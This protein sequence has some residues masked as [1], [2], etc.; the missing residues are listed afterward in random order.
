MWKLNQKLKPVFWEKMPA[1]SFF[2]F[3]LAVFFLFSSIGFVIDILNLGEV[4]VQKLVRN[5]LY[6]GLVA[7]GFAYSF[8]KNIKMLPV[9]LIFQFGFFFLPWDT[10]LPND[11]TI[12]QATQLYIDG[13]GIL[14]SIV[15]SY[16]LFV[17]FISSQGIKQVRLRAEMDIAGEMHDVLVPPINFRN[18]NLC[19]Y[20]KSLPALEVGGDLIDLYEKDGSLTCYIADVS[21]HGISAGLFN[22]YV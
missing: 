3:V 18:E 7:T 11:F 15:I 9:T 17:I 16:T 2:L 12:D 8:T 21:G 20:G 14:S 19:I 6:C 5:V 1:K 4:G 22:G 13:F 10:I